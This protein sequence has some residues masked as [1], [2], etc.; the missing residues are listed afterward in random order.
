MFAL[1]RSSIPLSFS[2]K[3]GTD[4][5]GCKEMTFYRLYRPKCPQKL[6]FAIQYECVPVTRLY[7]NYRF[8]CP[9]C[10]SS[11]VLPGIVMH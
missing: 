8:N 6:Y 9:P 3:K 10:Q 5:T 7:P 11:T 4:I 1:I 2:G